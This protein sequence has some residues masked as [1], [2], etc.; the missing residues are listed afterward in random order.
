MNGRRTV[1]GLGVERL[2]F[3]GHDDRLL[4]E[5]RRLDRTRRCRFL[6]GRQP[7]EVLPQQRQRLLGIDVTHDDHGHVGRDVVPGVEG[8]RVLAREAL[9]VAHVTDVRHAVGMGAVGDGDE[10][11]EQ[12]A[13]GATLGAHAPLFL[14]HVALAVELAQHRI[15]ET[16]AFQVREQLELVGRQRVAVDRVIGTG[17]GVQPD[18]A[19]AV[20][21]LAE[22]V[23]GDEIAGLVLR[24]RELRL[25]V[26]QFGSLDSR[27]I[28]CG[29]VRPVGPVDLGHRLDLGLVV[30]GADLGRSLERHVLE[31]VRE[32]D[33]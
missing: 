26:G 4:D 25:E 18:P 33:P 14:N 12:T 1:V 13:E 29:S 10:L 3:V 15:E 11:L 27:P 19:V 6:S 28:P 8:L 17:R 16:L 23:L 9:Q 7:P 20:D 31:H 24:G 30:G 21:D 22:L 5:L 32:R 2:R